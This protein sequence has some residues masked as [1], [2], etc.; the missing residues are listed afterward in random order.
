MT[1]LR[2]PSSPHQFSAAA[3]QSLPGP[4]DITR[5]QLPNGIVVLSRPNFNNPSVVVK[6]YL[7]AGGLFDPDDRLGLADFTASALMRGTALRTFQEI[8]DSLESV[9]ASLGIGGNTHTAGF[10]GKALAEDLDM[11]LTLLA[12]ILRQPV[13]PGQQVE[14][15]RSQL[16]TSLAIRAQDTG[17]MAALTFDQIVYQGHPYS[18]PE[19]GYPET[20]QAI[21]Q[22]DLVSFHRQ[23]YGARGL[24]IAIVGAV[25]PD[26]AIEK[27][28][29]VLGDWRN[30]AQP[31]PP[32]LPGVQPLEKVIFQC[33]PIPGKPQADIVIGSAG[34]ART[35]AD[36]LAASLGNSVLGLFGM[37]G[38]VGES[39]RE[40]AGLAYYAASSLSGGLGPGP[41]SVSAGANPKDVQAVIDLVQG[42]IRRFVSEPISAEEL[43]DNQAH[44]IGRL[45]LSLESNSGIASALLNLER[46][47]LGMDYYQRFAGLVS[48]IT[49]EDVLQAARHYLNPEGLCVA[50]AGEGVPG[51]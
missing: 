32:A 26:L 10:G 18:R 22:D 47:Q 41:W 24:T 31:E 16:L 50:V 4:E 51:C 46:Y 21:Q 42:E 40:K 5:L 8:Y 20:I 49:A 27:V 3:G 25:D 29:R 33:V 23:H 38:R 35:A 37:M 15:L 28:G 1:K 12:E 6:G 7:T 30:P 9:G 14:R 17:E 36:Y 13:F 11:L 2:K 34:P 43:S 45:P 44:F 39:V 19:D 48:A